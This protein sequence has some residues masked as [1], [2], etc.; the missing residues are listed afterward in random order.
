MLRGIN[1]T[2]TSFGGV[3]RFYQ[4]FERCA[5]MVTSR[6][7]SASNSS[8]SPAVVARSLRLLALWHG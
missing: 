5:M 8:A 4:I 2:T 1:N 3:G 6:L 7:Q